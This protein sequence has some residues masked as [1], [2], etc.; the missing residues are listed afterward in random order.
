MRADLRCIASC[1]LYKHDMQWQCARR[2]SQRASSGGCY[3][4]R[5]MTPPQ[6]RG[7]D[8][9][10]ERSAWDQPARG[11]GETWFSG[12]DGVSWCDRMGQG[13]EMSVLPRRL[14]GC[15]GSRQL[16]A[17][18][19]ETRKP[20]IGGADPEQATPPQNLNQSASLETIERLR[21]LHICHLRPETPTNPTPLSGEGRTD[22]RRYNRRLACE[23]RSPHIGWEL[24]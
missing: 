10:T 13:K 4:E 6:I 23:C 21:F 7:L 19:R 11:F 22:T 24:S 17:L 8:A 1:D 20:G 5:A 2:L 15:P 18:P 12:L 9:Q 16:S 14:P 3:P